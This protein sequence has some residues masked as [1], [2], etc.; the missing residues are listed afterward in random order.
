MTIQHSGI[1]TSTSVHSQ[2]H[3][4]CDLDMTCVTFMM[5]CRSDGPTYNAISLPNRHRFYLLKVRP[6]KF[7]LVLFLNAV[8]IKAVTYVENSNFY[9]CFSI[10]I[11]KFWN[12]LFYKHLN[13]SLVFFLYISYYNF[14]FK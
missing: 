12:S 5:C 9:L 14:N 8:C 3:E 6:E 13:F 11:I 1:R 2:G 7:I 4:T 10:S